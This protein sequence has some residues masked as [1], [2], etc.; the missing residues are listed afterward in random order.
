MCKLGLPPESRAH[1]QCIGYMTAWRD[2][3]ESSTVIFA[4]NA[5]S[6]TMAGAVELYVTKHPE[7][8]R[9]NFSDTLWRALLDAG[10]IKQVQQ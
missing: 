10:L 1:N 6:T 5:T 9:N 2:T 4:D 8:L 7:E 3:T